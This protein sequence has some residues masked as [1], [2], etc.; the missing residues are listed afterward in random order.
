MNTSNRQPVSMRQEKEAQA[1]PAL[2]LGEDRPD[3]LE[4]TGREGK[5]KQQQRG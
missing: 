5:L 1:A 2:Q 4:T 3:R